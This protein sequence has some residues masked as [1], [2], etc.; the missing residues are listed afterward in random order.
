MATDA[1]AKWLMQAAAHNAKGW[2]TLLTAREATLF[3]TLI[4]QER[5]VGRLDDDDSTLIIIQ[6]EAYLPKRLSRR[7]EMGPRHE[8]KAFYRTQ[9]E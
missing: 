6:P 2:S 1:L 3:Q 5:A 4:E 8:P 7:S 9:E